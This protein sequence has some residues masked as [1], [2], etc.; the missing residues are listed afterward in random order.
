MRNLSSFLLTF[1]VLA[2]ASASAR[3]E[4]DVETVISRS[5][6]LSGMAQTI[7]LWSTSGQPHGTY[8]LSNESRSRTIRLSRKTL[9]STLVVIESLVGVPPQ[10]PPDTGLLRPLC[11]DM[12]QTHI[13]FRRDSRVQSAQEECPHRTTVSESYWQRVDSLFQLLSSGAR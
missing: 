6:G 10:I 7:R 13:E 1:G 4:P 8:K 5:G 11:G 12:I 3:P 9:D 2:C